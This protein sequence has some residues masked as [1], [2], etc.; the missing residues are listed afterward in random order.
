M[1]TY[2]LLGLAAFALVSGAT[3]AAARYQQ[4][5]VP[6]AGIAVAMPAEWVPFSADVRN[7]Y[8]SSESVGTFHRRRDGSEAWILETPGGTAITIHN[9]ATQRTY[10]KLSTQDW[11]SYLV[12]R[13]ARPRPQPELRLS[14]KEITVTRDPVLG[15]VYEH[16]HPKTGQITRLAPALN[17][18]RLSSR[19][20]DGTGQELTNIVLG[21]PPDS[22]FLPPAGVRVD[23][24]AQEIGLAKGPGPRGP[25]PK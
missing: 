4:P 24:F 10:V 22:L 3:I 1:R 23:E 6:Y 2:F 13:G 20:P 5:S 12:D 15:D 7:V 25:A 16:T 19:R 14:P 8:H 18:A 17:G 11:K 21:D 9:L